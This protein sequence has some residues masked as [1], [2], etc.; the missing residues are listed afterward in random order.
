MALV[1]VTK[2]LKDKTNGN[3]IQKVKPHI[4]SIFRFTVQSDIHWGLEKLQ[5][6]LQYSYEVGVKCDEPV[7]NQIQPMLVVDATQQIAAP[8]S[9]S[10]SG[11][12][13]WHRATLCQLK[14]I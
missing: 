11:S 3:K 5:S 7:N 6:Q 4:K 1:E 12:F 10:S 14:E 9:N 8:H 13:L 2:T